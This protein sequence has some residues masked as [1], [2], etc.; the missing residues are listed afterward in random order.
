[1]HVIRTACP[2][3][4]PDTCF[5]DV[6]VDEGKIVKIQGSTL[7]PVTRGFLCPRGAGDIK[8]VYSRDRVLYPHIRGKK[9]SNRFVRNSWDDALSTVSENL[10]RIMKVHGSRSLLLYDYCGN[11]GLLA[12]QFPRRLWFAL[13]ATTTDY[14]LCS[15]SG[16]AG[17]G[18]HYGLG[19][20]IQPEELPEMKVILFWGN[21]ARVSSPHQWV[22]AL[23]AR[24]NGNATIISVDPR[25]SPT[26]E[27]A[28]IWMNPRPGTDVAL[29]Y[30]IA[31]YLIRREGGGFGVR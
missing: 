10:S 29:S 21:N 28:D 22:Y 13:G 9:R 20:G 26:S 23:K 8:R 14:S 12:W 24:S 4:C 18:L 27:A 15:S 16:H 25:K 7:N 31:R 3:D 19:Y 2:R 17:I 1:M 30:G 5:I 6:T 11:Q